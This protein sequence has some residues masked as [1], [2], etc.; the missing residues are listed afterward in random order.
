[1]KYQSLF[2]VKNKKNI[3][4]S[5][6]EL[7]KRVVK[8]KTQVNRSRQHST[9]FIFNIFQRKRGFILHVNHLPSLIF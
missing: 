8:V 6:T 4:L 9:I 3:N 5:S 7:V 1:M 2:S